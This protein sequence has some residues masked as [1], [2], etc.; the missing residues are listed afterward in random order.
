[1]TLRDTLGRL[2][3][4]AILFPAWIAA[5][6]LFGAL[7]ANPFIV[8]LAGYT[9]AFALFALS[10][11]LMLGGLGEVPLG[12]CLFYGIGAYVAAI[13]MK[14]HGLPFELGLLAAAIVAT[15]VAAV[16]GALTLRLTGAFFSIVSW[17]L[18]GVALVAAMNL[19]T[20]TGGPLGIFGFASL[21]VAGIDLTEPRGYFYV[22][23]AF[24]V[25]AVWLLSKVRDSRFGDAIESIRQNPHLARSVGVDVFRQRLKLFLLSAPIAA[26]GG[27]LSIPYTQIVTPEVFAVTNTVDALLMVLL[28][29]S[30]LLVGPVIGAVIFSVIPHFV[31]MDPNVRVLVFSSAIVLIMMFAPGGLHQLARAIVQRLSGVRHAGA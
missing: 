23:A 30:R 24:L 29:G 2:L 16:V 26:I 3:R 18:T 10:I 5:I 28:G 15:L 31:E 1:M 14:T 22:S 25:V 20:L 11:N 4:P 12:Q 17:G 7:V 9:S 13:A 6:G 19:E 21:S 27:A 8:T